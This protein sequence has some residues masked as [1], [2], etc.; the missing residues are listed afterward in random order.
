MFKQISQKKLY[1]SSQTVTMTPNLVVKAV[2]VNIFVIAV[3]LMQEITLFV[4][5]ET[6]RRW[7]NHRVSLGTVINKGLRVT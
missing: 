4:S 7:P 6:H 3:S 1:F 2:N 5:L